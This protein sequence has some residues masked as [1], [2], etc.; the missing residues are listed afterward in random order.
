[1]NTIVLASNNGGKLREFAQL[2]APYSVT[3]YPQSKFIAVGADETGA[4]FI[5]NALLKAR[6]ASQAAGLPAIA[7]DSGI[8]VDALAGAP[9]VYSARFAGEHATDEDNNRKLLTELAGLPAAQRSARFRCA[10]AY[11]RSAADPAPIVAEG[12]WEGHVLEQQRGEN[13]FG[14]DVL[15]LPDGHMQTA[16]ELSSEAKNK[17]SHRG[18]ALRALLALLI[19]NRAISVDV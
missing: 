17:V 10:L 3:L 7:D 2:L 14:Y 4:T 9:G 8:E 19:A 5:D 6:H 1:M 16:A 15:F 11:V 12:V 18:Q 13:G